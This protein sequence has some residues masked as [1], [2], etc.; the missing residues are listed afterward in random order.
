MDYPVPAYTTFV[1]PTGA[2]SG[3]RIVFNDPSD[4]GTI[5]V[6]N[7]SNVLVDRIG[8]AFGVIASFPTGHT[9]Q[10]ALEN[11]TIYFGQATGGDYTSG[12]ASIRSGQIDGGILTLDSGLGLIAPF[13]DSA[14]VLLNGGD[15]A[16]GPGGTGPHVT[17]IDS[18]NS[19]AVD[20]R[21][22]GA[23]VKCNN[24]GV[25]HVWH[26]PTMN[27]NWAVGPGGGSVQAL[28]YRFD[29][30]DNVFLEGV[31]HTLNAAP[32]GVV[33]NIPAPYRPKIEKR[34][35]TVFNNAGTI[36]AMLVAVQ[37]NGDIVVSPTPSAS[38]ADFQVAG[39]YSLGNVS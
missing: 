18:L 39:F 4:P 7:S 37:T 8:G 17:V 29:S 14:T 26:T 6:Y 10:V 35:G 30:E 20:M 13:T 36:T 9:A 28:Q 3:A 21:V 1:I 22:S 15:S 33:G 32:G 16:Q 31:A 38:G 2:T 5:L 12:A 11:G 27:A 25:P 24:A 23:V 19:S 34:W